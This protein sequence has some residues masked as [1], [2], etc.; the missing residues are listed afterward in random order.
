MVTELVLAFP[1][2]ASASTN[3]IPPAHKPILGILDQHSASSGG[4]G[5]VQPALSRSAALELVN[6]V[7]RG[8]AAKATLLRPLTLDPDQAADAGEVVPL[9][10]SYGVG[11][12][13]RVLTTRGDTL[14]LTGVAATDPELRRVHWIVKPRLFRLAGGVIPKGTRGVRYSLRSS[15]AGSGVIVLIDEFAD[16]SADDS[17]ETAVDVASREVIAAQPLALRCP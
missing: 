14:L 13:A 5:S 7:V 16:V 15:V 12:R 10:S 9:G 6:R 17:R 2:G 1:G 4:T 3:H 11:F 8:A